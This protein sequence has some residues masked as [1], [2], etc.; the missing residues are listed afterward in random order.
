MTEKDPVPGFEVLT[1]NEFLKDVINLAYKFQEIEF[2]AIIAIARGGL[3]IARLLSD[4]TAV[5]KIYSLHVEYY[6]GPNSRGSE[7]HLKEEFSQPIGA[8]QVIVVDDIVDTGKTMQ[9]ALNYLR[10]R[11]FK[12]LLTLSVYLK[13]WSQFTPD[14]YSRVVNRWVVF[15]YEHFETAVAL[16]KQGY[17]MEDLMKIGLEPAVLE[18]LARMVAGRKANLEDLEGFRGSRWSLLV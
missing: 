10:R 7:P 15:P 14:Y 2:D 18:R 11:G 3:V 6:T 4:L 16:F 12:K 13:P 5:K 1:W 17:S 9:L 8:T